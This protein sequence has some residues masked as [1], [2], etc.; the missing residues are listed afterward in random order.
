MPDAPV[1]LLPYAAVRPLIQSG[2]LLLCS[3]SSPMSK[4]IQY[5]TGS[6]Y[7][8][9]AF[10]LRLDTLDRLV[11]LESVESIGIRACTLGSYVADY[12]GSGQPYPGS[13]WIARHAQVNLQE[14]RTFQVF[15]CTALD[16][17]GYPYG[18]QDILDITARIVGAK[19]GMPPRAV[20]TDKAY[21]CSEFAYLVYQ[22]IGVSVPYNHENFIAPADFATCAEV[23]LLWEIDTHDPASRALIDAA[24]M[25]V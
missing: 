14:A 7:S 3:G 13:L 22:S 23:T 17:L 2:D 11:V 10:L 24:R 18:T 6:H 1:P 21:I 12:N 15:S 9:V 25:S 5:S 20:R 19:L 8:H 16:L 4:M